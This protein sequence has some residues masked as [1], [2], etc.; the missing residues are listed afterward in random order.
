MSLVLGVVV[1]LLLPLMFSW[2]LFFWFQ[3]LVL[4][5]LLLLVLLVVP[6][7]VGVFRG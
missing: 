4:L 5:F 7:A 2:A 6:L 1:G 3:L